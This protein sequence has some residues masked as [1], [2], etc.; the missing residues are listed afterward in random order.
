[1]TLFT[2]RPSGCPSNVG[3]DKGGAGTLRIDASRQD[4]RRRLRECLR[5]AGAAHQSSGGSIAAQTD[6]VDR[7]A[8]ELSDGL[9]SEQQ[10]VARVSFRPDGHSKPLHSHC[11]RCFLREA[12]GRWI[13]GLLRPG[14]LTTVFQPIVRCGR[15][16]IFG[17]EALMRVGDHAVNSFDAARVLMAAREAGLALQLDRHACSTAVSEAARHGV[18]T[19]LFINVIPSSLCGTQRCINDAIS[20]LEELRLSPHQIVFELIESEPV[21]DWGRLNEVLGRYRACG[22]QVALDDFGTAYSSPRALCELRPDYIKLDRTFIHEVHADSWRAALAGKLIEAAHACGAKVVAEGVETADEYRWI[23][24]QG[25]EF[26]QGFYFSR[27]AAP[28]PFMR[29][30]QN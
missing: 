7:L 1:M 11:L 18:N 9:S 4:V 21:T 19:K 17:F 8:L 26:A 30:A 2:C 5:R 29:A 14:G 12:Q 27:P 13:A 24:E 6:D 16:E 10:S 28:P 15:R 22:F 20:V 25:V 23:V 3:V